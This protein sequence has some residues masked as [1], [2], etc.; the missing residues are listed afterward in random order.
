MKNSLDP[1]QLASPEICLSDFV[2][3]SNDTLEIVNAIS[4]LG[5]KQSGPSSA[6]FTRNELI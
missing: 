6:G 1:D 2:L 5:E 3:F 4:T